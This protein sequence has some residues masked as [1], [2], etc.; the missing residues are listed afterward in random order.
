M[1]LKS[2]RQRNQVKETPQPHLSILRLV[3]SLL[4]SASAPLNL[5]LT[6]RNSSSASSPTLKLPQPSLKLLRRQSAFS[7]TFS[8]NET[9]TSALLSSLFQF[10]IQKAL[11]LIEF[12]YIS[13][14]FIH[15]RLLD[16]YFFGI[17]SVFL[18]FILKNDII[19]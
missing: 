4:N 12:A 2:K 5:V 3:S 16:S 1:K 15:F 18:T 10:M 6:C 7:S 8:L 19:K 13:V 14:H 17:F 11:K 9:F